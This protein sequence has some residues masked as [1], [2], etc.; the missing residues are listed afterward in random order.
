MTQTRTIN[1]TPIFV[2]WSLIFVAAAFLNE[3][4]GLLWWAAGPWLVLLAFGMVVWVFAATVLYVKYRQGEP[5]TVTTRK[6]VRVVRRGQEPVWK[7][8]R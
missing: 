3:N 6:G 8:R 7:V 4:L 1:L 5:I 2:V